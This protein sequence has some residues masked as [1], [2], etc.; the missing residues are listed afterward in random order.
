[1]F[2]CECGCGGVIAEKRWHKYQRPRFIQGHHVTVNAREGRAHNRYEPKPEEIPSGSCECGCG[3]PTPIAKVT[4]RSLRHFRGHPIPYLSGHG[5]RSR[6]ADS[7]KWKGGRYVNS[8]GYVEVYSPDH[9]AAQKGYVREHRLVVEKR[10]G[11]YLLST[12][13]VHH[14]NHIKTDNRDENLEVMT[15]GE[16]TIEHRTG[17]KHAPETIEL[18]RAAGRKGAAI[19]WGKP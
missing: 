2:E 15:K 18:M 5:S 14:K 17:A 8:S 16:H 11:R 7:H 1:M 19:R 12:E 3:R 13:H 9:P 6:G 10:L 4:H